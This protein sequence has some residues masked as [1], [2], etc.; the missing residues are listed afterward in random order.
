MG[1]VVLV[2]IDLLPAAPGAHSVHRHALPLCSHDQDT[3]AP[4]ID[5]KISLIFLSQSYKAATKR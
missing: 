1:A 2:N 5:F 4:T 3:T